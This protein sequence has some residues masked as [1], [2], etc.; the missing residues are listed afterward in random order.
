MGKRETL[1]NREPLEVTLVK[2]Y[3]A[4]PTHSFYFSTSGVGPQNLHSNKSLGDVARLGNLTLRTLTWSIV[5]DALY[6]NPHFSIMNKFLLLLGLELPAQK[7]VDFDIDLSSA[8]H[9]ANNALRKFSTLAHF[10]FTICISSN[11]MVPFFSE[12]MR[13]QSG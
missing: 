2:T 5:K 11:I 9:M 10:I 3:A 4:G 7:W 12:E 13:A 6:L 1:G 8:Y